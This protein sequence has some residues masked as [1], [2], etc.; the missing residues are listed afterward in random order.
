MKKKLKQKIRKTKLE[1][2]FFWKKNFEKEELKK[3]EKK[4]KKFW[5]NIEKKQKLKKYEK[6]KVEKRL[7]S[8]I[9]IKL[10]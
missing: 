4:V 1:Q 8:M 7:K 3:F 9:K 2:N 6:R 5:K 10:P